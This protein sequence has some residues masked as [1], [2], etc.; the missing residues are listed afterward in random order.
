ME[1]DV[2]GIE[3]RASGGVERLVDFSGVGF[4][5]FRGLFFGEGSKA[6]DSYEN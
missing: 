1:G 3:T 6:M 4:C 5:H 2:L